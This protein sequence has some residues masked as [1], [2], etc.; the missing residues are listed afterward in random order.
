MCQAAL[1]QK[2]AQ[3]P[4]PFPHFNPTQPDRS[5]LPA[6]G[7]L[8]AKTVMIFKTWLRGWMALGQPPR[9]QLAWARLVRALRTNMR[10]VADQAAAGQRVDARRFT[11]DYHAGN[12]AQHEV[13]QR[14]Q[15]IGLPVC[16]AA[17]AA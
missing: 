2:K 13:E 3:G 7:R 12:R 8:D 16:A 15:A 9:A 5:K 10:I 6:I 14:S 4:F 17:D 11:K 1:A